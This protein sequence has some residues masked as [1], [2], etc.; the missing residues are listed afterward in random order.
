MESALVLRLHSRL[1][2]NIVIESLRT[3]GVAHDAGVRGLDVG[4]LADVAHAAA[5]GAVLW[6]LGLAVDALVDDAAVGV[7]RA[8]LADVACAWWGVS[9]SIEVGNLGAV[10]GVVGG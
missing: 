10:E 1:G 6:V 3:G 9:V 8:V 2:H 7:G 5:P 4:R